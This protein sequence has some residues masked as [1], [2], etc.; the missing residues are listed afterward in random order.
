MQRPTQ[1]QLTPVGEVRS[2]IKAP[3]LLAGKAG[4]KLQERN[5][6]IKEYHE[7]VKNTLCEI[8]IYPQWVELLDGIEGFSHLLVLYWP[9]LIDPARRNLQK[10]HPIYSVVSP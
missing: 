7:K 2:E 10:V 8:V 1:M 5:Q 4:L 9:H 3:L 6:K